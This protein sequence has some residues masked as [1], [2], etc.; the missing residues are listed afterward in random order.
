MSAIL[1]G[2][3]AEHVQISGPHEQIL[4]VGHLGTLFPFL[5][6][7]AILFGSCVQRKLILVHKML[8][9]KFLIEPSQISRECVGNICKLF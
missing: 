7:V 4:G 9:L 3:E 5:S 6:V 8:K 2:V 1:K